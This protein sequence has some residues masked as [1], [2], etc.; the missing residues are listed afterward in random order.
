MSSAVS[1]GAFLTALAAAAAA[2]LRWP[3]GAAPSRSNF[4]YIGMHGRQI[5]LAHFDAVN[6]AFTLVGHAAVVP[7][8][9]WTTV[10][11]KLP[12]IY[13]DSEVGGDGKT[14]GAV[15]ALRIDPASGMLTTIRKVNARGGGTTYLWLDAPSMTLLATNYSTGSVVTIP[16]D[17]DGSPAPVASCVTEIGSGP[18]ARQKSAHPHSVV[19]DPSGH[20][21]L[22]PDLGAD[23]VF[24]YPFDRA[25]HALRPDRPGQERHFVAPPGSGPRHIVFH[26]NGR[27]VY[28]VT[29]LTAD[30][31]TLKW[32]A[33]AGRLTQV[34]SISM[35]GPEFT[36]DSSAAELAISRD[37]RFVYGSNRGENTIVAFSV[38]GVSGDLTFLQR[39]PA[40]GDP[41]SFGLHPSGRWM[42]VAN[43]QTNVVD[44][45]GVDPATGRINY[46]GTTVATPAPVSISF[47]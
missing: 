16:V 9:T 7:S 6:G 32:D 30:V 31:L 40:G 10:H 3:L 33:A 34:A 1:R 13:S 23:R 35:N 46:T 5:T 38:N 21:A 14:D 47:V 24:V 36:G 22:V 4:V 18:N 29:E 25:S 41:W 39:V 19:V 42:L 17:A 2:A 43:E 28:L 37:G 12:I 20:F 27:F 11:P 8:P 45:V 44:V 26:P 15:Y